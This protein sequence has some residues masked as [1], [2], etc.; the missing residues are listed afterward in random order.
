MGERGYA[1]LISDIERARVGNRE[2]D[3]DVYEFFGCEV[4][5]H[6][7]WR[8]FNE[9]T[10]RW[11]ALPNLSTS[12]DDVTREVRRRLPDWS[13]HSGHGPAGRSSYAG[14]AYIPGPVD[15]R[16]FGETETLARLSVLIR[17]YTWERQNGR[18]LV[19]EER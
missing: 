19:S 13:L 14:H 6:G 8:W 5:R 9:A 12:L 3:A 15:I 1:E 16:G 4:R 7:S 10:R 2:L 18:A 11:E 17:A